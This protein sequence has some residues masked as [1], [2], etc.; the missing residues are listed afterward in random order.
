M[1]PNIFSVF[2]LASTL[3]G[4]AHGSPMN[5]TDL[6]GRQSC[7]GS[8]SFFTTTPCCAGLFCSTTTQTCGS[9]QGPGAF[10][11]GLPC[12]SGVICELNNHSVASALVLDN[13]AAISRLS[14]DFSHN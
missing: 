4:A 10:C 6:E 5:T 9:C 8:G 12:C 1:L 7:G 13:R 11:T 14:I 3:L 2:V